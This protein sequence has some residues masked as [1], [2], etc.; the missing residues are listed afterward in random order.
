MRTRLE[1]Q[2]AFEDILGSRNVY[3]Q[4]P[5]SIRMSYPAIVYE[6]SKILNRFAGNGKYTSN[7]VYDAVLITN[8]PD[9]EFIEPILSLPYCSYDRHYV[10]D[11]LH[12]DAFT[13]YL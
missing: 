9:S 6:R 10:A 12:H 13:I 11:N 5:S 3:F 1:L 4:P 8:S 7:R 2:Q